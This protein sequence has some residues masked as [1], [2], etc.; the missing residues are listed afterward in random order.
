M[1]EPPSVFLGLQRVKRGEV[2]SDQRIPALLHPGS[3]RS[4]FEKVLYT[5]T[6]YRSLKSGEYVFSY[7]LIVMLIVHLSLGNSLINKSSNDAYENVI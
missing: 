7:K 5:V 6:V 1:K 2:R 4:G 3:G